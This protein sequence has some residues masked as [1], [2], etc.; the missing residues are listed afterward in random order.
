MFLLI[1][2]DPARAALS[3][4]FDQNVIWYLFSVFDVDA[5]FLFSF[6]VKFDP[7]DTRFKY[8]I[9]ETLCA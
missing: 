3:N 1:V 6:N 4:P 8:I 2:F 9:L 5:A 7:N